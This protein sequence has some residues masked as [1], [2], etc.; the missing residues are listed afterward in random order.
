MLAP[1]KALCLALTAGLCAAV[2]SAP[3]HGGSKCWQ[4]IIEEWSDR[5]SVSTSY[6]I[7]CYEAAVANAP[8][9]LLLYSSFEGDVFTAKRRAVRKQS[10]G[11]G[12][13]GGSASGGADRAEPSAPTPSGN[14]AKPKKQK[15]KNKDGNEP[16]GDGDA[17]A[18]EGPDGENV[19][20]GIVVGD[21]PEPGAGTPGEAA[22]GSS[23]SA[24]EADS[25]ATSAPPAATGAGAES[26]DAEAAAATGPIVDGGSMPV[27]LIALVVL[28]ALLAL[29]GGTALLL[30]R[31]EPPAQPDPQP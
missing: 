30:G 4:V 1:L 8:D 24:A 17:D 12:S 21:P 22:G 14:D 25:A 19:L 26:L 27:A 9:D 5:G 15:K 11:G 18:Q 2:L 3:A 6:D 28:A 20:G 10:R 13:S 31:R 29:A 23:G 7:Q 16:E